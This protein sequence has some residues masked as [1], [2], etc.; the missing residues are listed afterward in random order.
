MYE[1]ATVL[2]NVY[3]RTELAP[4]PQSHDDAMVVETNEVTERRGKM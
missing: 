1:Y 3:K 4:L 2:T